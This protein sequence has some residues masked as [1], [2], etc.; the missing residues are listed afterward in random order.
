ME[1]NATTSGGPATFELWKQ[2]LNGEFILSTIPLLDDGKCLF[3]CIDIDEY[4][5]D[6]GAIC[7]R[8]DNLKLP[9]IPCVSKSAGLHLFVLFKEP[10]PAE[11]VIPALRLWA[12]Q[13]GLKGFE[14][15][16]T[17][18]GADKL[19]RAVAM[20]YGPTWD[21]LPEQHF[22]GP[23]GNAW[24]LD[25]F[26]SHAEGHKAT[27]ED[28]PKPEKESAQKQKSRKIPLSLQAAIDSMGPYPGGDRSPVVASIIWQLRDLGFDT[29]EIRVAVEHRGPFAR[30]D[31]DKGKSLRDDIARIISKY[32]D[33][34]PNKKAKVEI[35][36]D[37]VPWDPSPPWNGQSLNSRRLVASPAWL[38]I[39]EPEKASFCGLWPSAV[40]TA[41]RSLIAKCP[42][43]AA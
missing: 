12:T 10:V 8:I 6:Y 4:N 36:T 32:D 1:L 43:A 11:L 19:T 25:D 28:L 7:K 14:V 27:T 29:D 13:L 15:F 33:R 39:Q 17:S 21:A 16:P 31:E 42:N 40:C 24:L 18:A 20:P 34:H 38:A 2:H 37:I 30:Y 23:T 26:I 9:L 35:C 22:L 41:S 5:L 3:A